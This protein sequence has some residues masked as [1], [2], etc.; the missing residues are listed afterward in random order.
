MRNVG[1]YDIIELENVILTLTSLS[2]SLF[3][4]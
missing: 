3:L 2:T 4:W 1:I